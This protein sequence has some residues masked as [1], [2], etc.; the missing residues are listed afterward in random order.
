MCWWLL[1]WTAQFNTSMLS[2][3]FY[4]DVSKLTQSN[5]NSW[6]FFF[7]PQPVSPQTKPSSTQLLEPKPR[8]YLDP[9]L[10]LFPAST[11]SAGPDYFTFR[12]STESTH[13]SPSL[14][15]NQG[16]IISHLNNWMASSDCWLPVI[17]SFTA[18]SSRL[19]HTAT[20]DTIKHFR[21]LRHTLLVWKHLW[22]IEY[23]F[24]VPHYNGSTIISGTLF[25]SF[26]IVSL[27]PTTLLSTQFALSKPLNNNSMN[28]YC[29][30]RW[31]SKS[32]NAICN[33]V[34][35]SWDDAD[36]HIHGS[37]CFFCILDVKGRV[38]IVTNC[39]YLW[40][41]RL[42]YRTDVISAMN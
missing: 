4:L 2:W 15:V 31:D 39:M 19:L 42:V 10:F 17:H 35:N 30:R 38:G 37:W 5:Q 23:L 7:C 25:T 16:I 21:R 29:G 34:V 41:G 40:M 18:S 11:L 32:Q 24:S 20:K 33:L 12:T 3:H 14:L 13:L 9:F 26:N 28:I 36:I 27:A 1:Y 8:C 6:F 22:D